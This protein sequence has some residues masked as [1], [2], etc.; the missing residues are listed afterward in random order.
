MTELLSFILKEVVPLF[1]SLDCLAL[2]TQFMQ[3]RGTVINII[4]NFVDNIFLY[5]NLGVTESTY[6]ENETT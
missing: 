2:K 5:K 3:R 1:R 4:Y 6:P